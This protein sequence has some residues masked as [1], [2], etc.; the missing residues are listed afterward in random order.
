MIR[1]T[2][3]NSGMDTDSMV[4]EL[5]GT[6]EKKGQKTKNEK[7]KIEWKQ[8]IWKDLNK[9]IKN[10]AS[11]V[12]SLQYE[13]NYAQ[14]KTVSSDESKVSVVAGDK[15]V[16]G[17]QTI[18]V[19]KLAST[20]YYTSSSV[21]LKEGASTSKLSSSTKLSDL[22]IDGESKTITVKKATGEP[23]KIEVNGDL[24]VGQFVNKVKAAGLDASFDDKTGRF[25]VSAKQSGAASDFE[26]EGDADALSALGLNSGT[27]IPGQ[28]AKILL[29]GAEFES[30][31]NSFD[32]NG[33]AINVKGETNGTKLTLTT[34]TD[35]E[36]IYN[37]IKSVI[38]QYSEL[39]N[40]ISKLYNADSAKG[41][42]PLTDDEKDEMSDEEI[43]KWETKIKDSLLRRDSSLSA[44][45][46]AMTMASLSSFEIGGK[47]YSL[48]DFG[49]MT[50]GYF[51][52]EDNEKS[53][54]HINGDEDDDDVSGKTNELK[55][56]LAK[57]P[58]TVA[59][60]FSKYMKTISDS[61][62]KLSQSTEYRSYGN[63]YDDKKSKKE[64]SSIESK[65]TKWEDYVADI[66]D[67]YYKQFSNMEKQLAKLN[68]TQSSLASY[69]GMS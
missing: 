31:T 4:K 68:S 62:D 60:F 36:T 30:D 40:E 12:R 11:K 2:G 9:K 47:K 19:E 56:M 26:F 33:M 20:A 37:N 8:D 55:Q 1:I 5:V 59:K 53:A 61:L 23:V 52:A 32:I 17:T 27:R 54:L 38:K 21:S 14:K 58:D 25:F 13:G 65:I 63:F 67:K 43:E 15:A 42:D 64:L 10:F 41:Y 46:N 44:V 57:D 49:I 66:E 50:L 29:N 39:V 22:G 35:T 69:F 34:D 18:E 16:R 51:D 24:T 45:K 6:Y 3:M 28:N 7:T 48:S